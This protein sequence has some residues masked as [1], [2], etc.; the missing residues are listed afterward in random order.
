MYGRGDVD[1]VAQPRIAGS[2]QMSLH[3]LRRPTEAALRIA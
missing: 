3:P 2:L 1:L